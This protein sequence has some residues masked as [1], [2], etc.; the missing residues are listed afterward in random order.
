MSDNQYDIP[1]NKKKTPDTQKHVP[2]PP[3]ALKNQIKPDP[4]ISLL[5]EFNPPTQRMGRS[6]RYDMSFQSGITDI[7]RALEEE[8]NFENVSNCSFIEDDD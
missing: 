5:T 2:S 6:L 4:E 8:E 3:A 7:R 1:A